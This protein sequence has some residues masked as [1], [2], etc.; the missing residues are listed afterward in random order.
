[1]TTKDKSIF[2]VGHSTMAVEHLVQLLCRHGVTLVADVRTVPRSRLNPQ[3]NREALPHALEPAG[4]KYQHLPGLGG[5]RRPLPASPNAG[6][7]NSAFRGFADY[8]LTEEFAR[9]LDG[10]VELAAGEAPALMCAEAVPWRC[11]RS[12]IA[13]ALTV[14]GLPVAHILGPGPPRAHVLTPW[15]V[16]AGGR[17]TYPPP[18][19][20]A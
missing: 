16:L 8:M 2:T 20:A 3:F 9:A 13:D 5:L 15:A 19:G 12:L 7:R 6:W 10:L 11:H 14:R 4:L 18:A 17:L 1:M